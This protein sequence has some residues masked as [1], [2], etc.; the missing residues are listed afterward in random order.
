MDKDN[1]LKMGL[2]DK[3][4]ESIKVLDSDYKNPEGA[5]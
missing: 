5:A 2:Q 4:S 3:L 1:P